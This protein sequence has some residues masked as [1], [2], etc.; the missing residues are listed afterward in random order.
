MRAAILIT[1][2]QNVRNTWPVVARMLQ[3]SCEEHVA[4][5]SQPAALPPDTPVRFIEPHDELTALKDALV[6]SHDDPVLFMVS[7]FTAP[8]S[9]LARYMEFVRAGYDA[10]VPRI[11]GNCPE[12][13]FAIYTQACMAHINSALASARRS[14]AD[15]LDELNVRYVG[16]PEVAK[17]GE[18]SAILSRH[19]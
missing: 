19:S 12:P 4:I 6:W 3:V 13:L 1:D 5:I 18:P 8:S 10:V 11:D 15:I 14:I 17:F 2:P 7:D 9:E 16:K